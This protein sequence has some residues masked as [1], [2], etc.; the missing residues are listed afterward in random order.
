MKKG[1]C[2]NPKK[3]FRNNVKLWWFYNEIFALN[4]KTPH[5]SNK[6]SLRWI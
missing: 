5:K 4:F 2:P 6:Y 3:I 1:F